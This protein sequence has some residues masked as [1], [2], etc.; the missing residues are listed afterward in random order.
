L[1]KY[2]L[3]MEAAHPRR[4]PLSA[5]SVTSR[6]RSREED[7]RETMWLGLRLTQAG[8][9][10]KEFHSRFGEDFQDAFRPAV[11]ESIAEGL[12]EWDGE[13]RLRLTEEGRLLGNR[14][15]SRFV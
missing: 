7:M 1:E 12:L 8:V 9:S 14:V 4:F 10:R 6:R 2:I 11:E 3:R 15:F 5:A 13:D